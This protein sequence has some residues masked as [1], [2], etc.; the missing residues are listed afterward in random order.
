MRQTAVA[1]LRSGEGA[2][3]VAGI[4]P[5]PALSPCSPLAEKPPR[6]AKRCLNHLCLFSSTMAANIVTLIIPNNAAMQRHSWQVWRVTKCFNKKHSTV[7]DFHV[8]AFMCTEEFE[9]K[10]QWGQTVHRVPALT[11]SFPSNLHFQISEPFPE[12]TQGLALRTR[13]KNEGKWFS[14]HWRSC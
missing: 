5:A 7:F 11:Q 8:T 4:L 12:N 1:K 14:S 2:G 6:A 3:D 9:V 13:R 10:N